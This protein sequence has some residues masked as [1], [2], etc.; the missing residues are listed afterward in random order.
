MVHWIAGVGIAVVLPWELVAMAREGHP[1]NV[2]GLPALSGPF[3]RLGIDWVVGLGWG[4]VGLSLLE[5]LV[6][7]LV[8][9][10]R[11]V[12]AWL[13]VVLTAPAIV[14]WAG[15][16]LPLPPLVAALRLALLWAGRRALR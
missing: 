4:Y 3:E 10:R 8:W 12:G 9:R 13:S 11:R 16:A 15:F 1:V 5:V 2:F 6:G 14:F 7:I